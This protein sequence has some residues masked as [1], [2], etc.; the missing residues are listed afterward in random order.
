MPPFVNRRPLWKSSIFLSRA[1]IKGVAK[2]TFN[3]ERKGNEGTG[4]Q[5]YYAC[6]L[7]CYIY[8]FRERRERTGFPKREWKKIG[9]EKNMNIVYNLQSF[10]LGHLHLYFVRAITEVKTANS[11]TALVSILL[12][13]AA[14]LSWKKC[15]KLI[16]SKCAMPLLLLLFINFVSNLLISNNLRQIVSRCFGRGCWSVKKVG[17]GKFDLSH[18]FRLS[19]T[20]FLR[21][22]HGRTLT[23][24]GLI[25]PKIS[26]PISLLSQSKLL[27]SLHTKKSA[28]VHRYAHVVK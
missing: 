3:L 8:F 18:D 1:R 4:K 2:K 20:Y 21:T 22:K 28:W 7:P 10:G 9:K 23:L 11:R 27:Q 5:F 13:A 26:N 19:H 6:F 14:T 24:S 16:F 25:P 17:Q 12:L 15:L